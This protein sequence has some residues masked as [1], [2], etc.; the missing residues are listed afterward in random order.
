MKLAFIIYDGLTALDFVGM[1]DPLTRLKTMGFIKDLEY[2]V[3]AL[4]SPVLSFE[5]LELIPNK[6]GCSLE[7]YDYIIIPGGN[8]IAELIK[9][10]A[11]IGWMKTARPEATMAAVCGGVII[12]GVL[13]LLAGKKATTHPAMVG[14]LK[15]YAQDV[16]Q[17]RIVDEGRI[18]TARGVTS[19]I[20]LGLYLCE[21]IAGRETREHIQ[22]QMDYLNY[23]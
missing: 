13:G 11:F 6:I 4:N 19:A 23:Q 7:G 17:D 3:C 1:F 16:A 15:N 12:L 8:G 2:D 20:D 9:D 21:K 18:I 5:R 14:Y 22:N 10:E